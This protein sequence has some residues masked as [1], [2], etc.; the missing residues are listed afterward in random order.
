MMEY[1]IYEK[2]GTT[3]IKELVVTIKNLR[4][5]KYT[6]DQAAIVSIADAKG[7]IIYV[8]D[9]FCEISQYK[10]DELIG[11]NHRLLNSGYHP[12]EYFKEMWKQIGSGNTWEGEVRNLKKDG[13]I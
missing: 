11:K 8:N 13:S 7:T 3:D 4:D 5:L 9:L 1:S 6:L 12:K 2:D 10:R